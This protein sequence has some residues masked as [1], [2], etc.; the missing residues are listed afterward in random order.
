MLFTKKK[1]RVVEGR[2][3]G[4]RGR[5]CSILTN[6]AFVFLLPVIQSLKHDVLFASRIF[7]HHSHRVF[8]VW[9]WKEMYSIALFL[10]VVV[11]LTV[12]I[13]ILVLKV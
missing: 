11:V 7:K 10:G 12:T 1:L 4:E 3:G 2:G 13:L 5:S 8:Q 9:L 6:V